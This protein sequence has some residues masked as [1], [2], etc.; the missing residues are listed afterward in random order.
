MPAPGTHEL[1]RDGGSGKSAAADG[2]GG[3]IW[4]HAWGIC[5][6]VEEVLLRVVAKDTKKHLSVYD[7]EQLHPAVGEVEDSVTLP[8]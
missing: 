3:G 7:R 4:S 1:R 5:R 8:G 6:E 2:E